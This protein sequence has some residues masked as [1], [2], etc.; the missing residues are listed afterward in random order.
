MPSKNIIRYYD[1]DRY[2]HVYNRGVEKRIIFLDD[3]DY[4]VFVNLFKRYLSDEP[5][6]DNKGRNYDWFSEDIELLAFCLMPNHF[7]LLVYQ[8]HLGAITNLLRSICATYT[9]YFNKKYDRVGPLFQGKFKASSI[10]NDAYL[11]YISRYI[12]R[13]PI[14]Y[15]SWEWS[16]LPYWISIKH[17][18]WLK[19]SRLNS[20]SP[21][22]Y[23]EF[24]NDE[25]DF[26][27]SLDDMQNE[28]IDL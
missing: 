18:S 16:S 19:N 17:S 13:N 6:S 2:Y 14:N 5:S 7:H 3:E 24:I 28:M 23:I 20:M 11:S 21:E 4:A 1:T 15:M 9:M 8:I 12:H 26:E 27:S 25:D 10:Q 22:Q